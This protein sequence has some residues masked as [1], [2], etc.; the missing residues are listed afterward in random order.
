MSII[1][2]KFIV[3]IELSKS[4]EN[5]YTCVI[6]MQGQERE[7]AQSPE[8][9]SYTF[10]IITFFFPKGSHSSLLIPW[11][12]FYIFLKFIEMGSSRVFS[13]VP[14]FFCLTCKMYPC[15]SCSYSSFLLLYRFPLYEYTTTDNVL[16]LLGI[17]VSIFDL[18]LLCP[19]RCTWA[20]F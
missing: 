6:T 5:E 2:I 18:W 3:K 20:C 14:G 15:V 12:C 16:L 11:I 4:S 10:A 8:A 1:H 17:W 13:F 9:F 7:C 19:L